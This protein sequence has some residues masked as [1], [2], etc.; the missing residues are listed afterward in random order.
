MRG[1]SES[2]LILLSLSLAATPSVH[3]EI[4]G[5]DGSGITL[6]WSWSDVTSQWTAV[7]REVRGRLSDSTL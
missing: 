3:S 6:G 1:I 4:S 2:V 7:V 5:F